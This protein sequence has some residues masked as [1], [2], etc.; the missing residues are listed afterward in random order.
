MFKLGVPELVVIFVVVI[1]LFG[2]KFLP[3]LARGLSQAIRNFRRETR[4]TDHE[5][6]NQKQD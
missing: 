5:A 3:G 6:E 1:L 4:K 2:V